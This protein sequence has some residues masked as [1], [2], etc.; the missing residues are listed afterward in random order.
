M[1]AIFADQ[2][3]REKRRGRQPASD[4]PFG[5]GC[6]YHRLAVAAGI[7][8]TADP[9]HPQGRR[10]PVEHLAHALADRMESTAAAGAV[11]PFNIEQLFLAI[12]MASCRERVCPYV[13]Y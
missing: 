7:F 1:I 9:D 6:L 3:M 4:H 2:H 8:G 11:I 10:Y 13:R 5:R 12:G